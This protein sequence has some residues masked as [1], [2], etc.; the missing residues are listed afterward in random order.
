[1]YYIVIFL[2]FVFLKFLNLD[3]FESFFII[4]ITSFVIECLLKASSLNKCNSYTSK[5][6][7]IVFTKIPF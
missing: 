6:H 2:K 7:L 1:M 5:M 4:D 3:I